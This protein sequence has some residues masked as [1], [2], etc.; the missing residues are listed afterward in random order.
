MPKETPADKAV[1]AGRLDIIKQ[2]VVEGKPQREIVR[3][4]N[5]KYPDWSLSTRQLRNYVYAAKRLLAKSAPNIDI[6][7]EF[8]LAKMRNDLLF[9]V[10]FE[11]KDTKTA[12][13]AN[14]ENIK[15]MRLND[16][17]FK[18]SWREK[19]EKAGINPDSAMDQFVSIL[20]EEAAKAHANT[21]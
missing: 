5:E 2:L 6:D 4:C 12:L 9:N 8:M 10:S 11:A 1:L 19:F 14:V 15:L 18:K 21:E 17:K 7:A 13:S 3:Y 20:K 16:P